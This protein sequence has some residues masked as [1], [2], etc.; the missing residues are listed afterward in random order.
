ML[1]KKL[2]VSV[3]FCSL[4]LCAD[5]EESRAYR[6]R[7]ATPVSIPATK[8]AHI[9]KKTLPSPLVTKLVT[10]REPIPEDQQQELFKWML[11]EKKKIKPKD[12]EEK[13]RI[14]EEKAIL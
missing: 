13:K 11:E 10:L 12:P 2:R 6:R 7:S 3:N 4:P 1:L 14:D 5:K 9:S 8:T